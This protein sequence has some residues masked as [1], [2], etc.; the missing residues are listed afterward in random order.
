MWNGV[1]C[2]K[3]ESKINCDPNGEEEKCERLSAPALPSRFSG[4]MDFLLR[5]FCR[6]SL[7]YF[8]LF[9]L[10]VSSWR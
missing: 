1:L 3:K 10:V 9:S 5:S 7:S 6:L 4:F 2:K 8:L